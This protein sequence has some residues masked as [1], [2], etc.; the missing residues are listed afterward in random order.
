[1][2]KKN[3]TTADLNEVVTLAVTAAVAA[4]MPEILTAVLTAVNGAP[5][6]GA[7]PE[8]RVRQTPKGRGKARRSTA[9][10]KERQVQRFVPVG[11][12]T[13]V[14]LGD[15]RKGAV[16]QLRP[17][18]AQYKVATPKGSVSVKLAHP[19]GEVYTK[20]GSTPVLLVG[21]SL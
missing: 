7:A 15:V 5:I 18:G 10:P 21:S 6:Q 20:S 19:S 13:D 1:M 2:A 4:A 14:L 11:T 16:V 17:D 12:L 9:A 3:T 8:G